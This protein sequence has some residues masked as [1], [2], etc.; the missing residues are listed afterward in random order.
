M[1]MTQRTKWSREGE[2]CDT[3][4]VEAENGMRETG[5]EMNEKRG[6]GNFKHNRVRRSSPLPLVLVPA[7]EP[8]REGQCRASA[9]PS[10]KRRPERLDKAAS[11]ADGGRRGDLFIHQIPY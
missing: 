4:P 7:S 5:M 2:R 8:I 3:R 11:G 1:P 10:R 9:N 6:D